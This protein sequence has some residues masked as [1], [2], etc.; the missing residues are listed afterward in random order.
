MINYTCNRFNNFVN[1][2]NIK[3]EEKWIPSRVF[4]V[5]C[6]TSDFSSKARSDNTIFEVIDILNCSLE[7]KE[8][9][10]VFKVIDGEMI[11]RVW[12]LQKVASQTLDNLDIY[13]SFFK[14]D[15]LFKFLKVKC[16]LRDKVLI[17]PLTSKNDA[18]DVSDK[19]KTLTKGHL[20][21]EYIKI[22]QN[23]ETKSYEISI[24]KRGFDYALTELY[25]SLPG[26]SG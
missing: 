21:P 19:I 4:G 23:P 18:K 25:Q 6:L 15:N 24:S 17:I 12:I 26:K 10:S 9:G 22:D 1:H 3:N 20:L 11:Y 8:I 16:K 13:S 14:T 7:K 5:A 2:Y